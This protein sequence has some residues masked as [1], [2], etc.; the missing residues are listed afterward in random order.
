MT[1]L[2]SAQTQNYEKINLSYHVVGIIGNSPQVGGT[3]FFIKKG[4]FY[5]L[6][7]S[8]HSFSFKNHITGASE[9]KSSHL[10]KEVIVYRNLEDIKTNNYSRVQLIDSTMQHP[11]YLSVHQNGKLLD[12]SAIRVKRHPPFE[13]DYYDLNNEGPKVETKIGADTFYYGFPIMNGKQSDAAEHFE[14]KISE[15]D[16]NELTM[17]IVGYMG[18]SGAPLFVRN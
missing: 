3:G 14:G 15:I 12:I 2:V 11:T 16:L 9:N 13:F 5:Y 4:Q 8:W 18:C 17:D 7:S 10:I 6:V 1:N